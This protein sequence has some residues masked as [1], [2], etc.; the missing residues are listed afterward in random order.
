MKTPL[1]HVAFAPIRLSSLGGIRQK[2]EH[3]DKQDPP[4]TISVFFENHFAAFF[5]FGAALRLQL[6]ARDKTLCK[7]PCT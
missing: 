4:K 7:F 2:Y 5:R 6:R 1:G 3:H